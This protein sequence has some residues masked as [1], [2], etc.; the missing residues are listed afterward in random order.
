M[1]EQHPKGGR[2]HYIGDFLF[3]GRAGSGHCQGLLDTFT[4]MAEW[5]KIPLTPEKTEG[6]ATCITFLGI[7]LDSVEGV[8]RLSAAKVQDLKAN[9][10]TLLGK[11]KATLTELQ[12]L[13]GKL[14]FAGRVILAGKAFAERLAHL[15]SPL[16]RKHH[17]ERLPRGVRQ[18]L[19]QWE[20]SCLTL[21]TC[22][23]GGTHR[24]P[25]ASWS[26]IRT[27]LGARA[28]ARFWTTI[29]AQ[30]HGLTSVSWRALHVT[31]PY[32]SCSPLWWHFQYGLTCLRTNR[33]RYG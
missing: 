6:P 3:L 9:I 8:C 27:Q 16:T 25:Q 5:L 21:M 23:C 15:T 22:C 14:N 33:S 29:G 28:S 20:D 32:W 31:S 19:E 18:D 4:C 26:F 12:Q 1:A 2:L 7:E 17:R 10:G 24:L 30:G 13:V 11:Q